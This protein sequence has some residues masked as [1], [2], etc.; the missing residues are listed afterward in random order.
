MPDIVFESLHPDVSPPRRGTAGSA[1]YDLAACLT[2]RTV[3]TWHEG[4][5]TERTAAAD[6][7]FTLAPGDKALIP[8]GF[9]AQLPPGIEAQIRP[10]SGTSVKTD[11][12]IAN[13]PGTVDPDYP[14]EWC[15]PVKNGGP[16]PLVIAHGDRIAQMVLARFET[17]GFTPGVVGQST[18]RAGGFGSTGRGRAG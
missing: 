15:V 18:D 12:V 3:R 17:L 10:R 8:L 4:V 9:K 5:M 1:G 16:A 7:T 2:G 13:A 6:G 11:L 14:D